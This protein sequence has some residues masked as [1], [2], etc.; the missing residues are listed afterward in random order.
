MT[1]H[2]TGAGTKPSDAVAGH[3]RRHAVDDLWTLPS[4]VMVEWRANSSSESRDDGDAWLLWQSALHRW[5]H[6]GYAERKTREDVEEQ[7]EGNSYWLLTPPSL[8][9]VLREGSWQPGPP[10]PSVYSN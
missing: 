1:V 9:A 3:K 2:A 5:S 6:D 10:H 7:G 8:V 4:G